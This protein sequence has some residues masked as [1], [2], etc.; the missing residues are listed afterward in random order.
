LN[1]MA[2]TRLKKVGTGAM[3]GS[4]SKVILKRNSWRKMSQLIRLI[5][6]RL[7]TGLGIKTAP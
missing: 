2:A 6:G 5:G 7:V 4:K 3:K 1:L